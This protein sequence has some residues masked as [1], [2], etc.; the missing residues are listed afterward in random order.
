MDCYEKIVPNMVPGGLLVADNVISHADELGPFVEQV[1]HAP[2][3]DALVVPIGKG[4][5]VVRKL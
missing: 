5:L 4:E 3:V 2:G 1:L